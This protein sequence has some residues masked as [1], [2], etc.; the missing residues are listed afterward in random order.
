MTLKHHRE[1]VMQV[2]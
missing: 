1:M 2:Q